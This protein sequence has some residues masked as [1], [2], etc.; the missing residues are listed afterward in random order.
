MPLKASGSSY[1][2]RPFSQSRPLNG[3][4]AMDSML[5]SS[6][7]RALTLMPSGCDRGT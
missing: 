6:M 2:A 5:P 1:A 7:Q 4:I 3:L